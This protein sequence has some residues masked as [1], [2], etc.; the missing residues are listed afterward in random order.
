M[1]TSQFALATLLSALAHNV[2][3]QLFTVNCGVLD[4][5]IQ[6][7][8]PLIFPGQVS[9]HVHVASGG[10]AFGQTESSSQAVNARATTCDKFY[11]KS[12]YWQPQLYH[13]NANGT[14]SLVTM[15][16]PAVYYLNRA[17]DYSASV[18]LQNPCPST[19]YARAPPAGLRMVVG[20]PTLR[21]YNGSD[22]NQQAVQ[23]VCLN[24][25]PNNSPNSPYLPQQPCLRMRAETFFPSCWDGVNLDSADHASHMAFPVGSYNGGYCP[26]SHPVAIYSVFYEFFYDTGA[27]QN[28]NRLV[29]AMGDPT[30]Y[31]LH[32]DYINGWNQT[33]L[34]NA[35][36]TCTGTNGVQTPSC[37]LWVPSLNGPG[38]ASSQT[39]QTTN[40]NPEPVGFQ[41]PLSALPGNNPV[42]GKI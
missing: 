42:T 21:T 27:I 14:F 5:S 18:N 31:G 28:F 12:S 24:A 39:V 35:M 33:A 26:K 7:A 19:F 22:F 32:G 30:G 2:A 13:Q 40:P 4:G 34:D 3:G 8:D 25:D 10:T 41:G 36:R 9:P 23:H 17:C 37:S 11:D 29:W 38:A 15:T 16:G 1:P 20:N 6:R